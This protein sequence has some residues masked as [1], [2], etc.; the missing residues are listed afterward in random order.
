[1]PFITAFPP[2]IPCACSSPR[3]I[4][5]WTPPAARPCVP[6]AARAAG[7]ARWIAGCSRQASST[8]SGKRRSTRCSP[9]WNSPSGGA[10]ELGTGRAAEVIDR[11]VNGVR[12]TVMP[13][14][15][16][17]AERSPDS[18][19]S[20]ILLELAQQVFDRF[21]PDVLLPYGGHPASLDLMRRAHSGDCRRLPPAQL[22]VQ[23]TEGGYSRND[24]RAFADVSTV[25]FSSE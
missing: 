11:G 15:Y 20:A 2:G 14:A 16:S 24:R 10:S 25:I 7:H 4:V 8:P 23:R 13:T 6:R 3:S 17:R 1:M 9:R 12:V 18:R 5:T 19:E 21:R 22:R